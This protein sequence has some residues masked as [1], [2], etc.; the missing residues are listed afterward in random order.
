MSLITFLLINKYLIDT[1]LDPINVEKPD[2]ITHPS[3]R[4][5]VIETKKKK[6]A[7]SNFMI[8]LTWKGRSMV[9]TKLIPFCI[10]NKRAPS[11]TENITLVWKKSCQIGKDGQAHGV[12]THKTFFNAL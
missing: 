4:T 12:P 3:G 1:P 8:R 11:R 2:D 10:N 9:L 5:F 6:N 7:V